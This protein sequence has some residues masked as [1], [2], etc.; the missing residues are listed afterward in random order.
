MK[1]QTI[2]LIVLVLLSVPGGS[3]KLTPFYTGVYPFEG[4][5]YQTEVISLNDTN[6]KWKYG[7]TVGIYSKGYNDTGYPNATF[8]YLFDESKNFSTDLSS[9]KNTLYEPGVG[10]MVD[11]NGF[12]DAKFYEV[13][14]YYNPLSPS[15][16]IFKFR[17]IIFYTGFSP[18]DITLQYKHDDEDYTTILHEAPV[19][20]MVIALGVLSIPLARRLKRSKTH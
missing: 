11:L 4:P 9:Y 6:I 15:D 10:G 7:E 16:D 14:E 5:G 2:I 8:V 17:V 20:S 13:E 12:Y 18:I 19:S 3:A 1:V